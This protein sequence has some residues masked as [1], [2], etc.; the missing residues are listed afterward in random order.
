MALNRNIRP[1][2]RLAKMFDLPSTKSFS[3]GNGLDVYFSEKSKLPIIKI[4][5]MIPAGSRYDAYGHE[6]LAYLTSLLID[7][8]AGTYNALQLANE[9]DKLGSSIDISTGVDYIF[10]SLTSLTENFERTLELFSLILK[11]PLFDQ[12]SFEREKEKHIIKIIQSFDDSSYI[13]A[14]AF[15]R[16]IFKGTPYDKP[17]LGFSNSIEPF[18]LTLV[19]DFYSSFFHSPQANLIVVGN[20]S[21]DSLSELLTKYLGDFNLDKSSSSLEMDAKINQAELFF[22]HKEDAAQSEIIAGHL[23]KDRD[24]RD[25]LAAKIANSILGGQFSSR[26]NL[27][28][29]EDKGYTYGAHSSLNYNK[30]LGYFS[31]NTSVQSEFTLNAINEIRKEVNLIRENITEEEISFTKSSLVK[32]F[33]SFFETY[34]QIAQRITTQ[35]THDLDDY[36]ENYIQNIWDLTQ[37]EIQT[38]AKEYFKP[39]ELC[40]FIV[41]N[42][43]IIYNDLQKIMDLQLVE[44]NKLGNPI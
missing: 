5:L 17:I 30:Y 43:D 34:S 37:D 7:E 38:A 21:E 6:G 4:N 8:G 18:N 32:Q 24:A 14:N 40:F 2:S 29:R 41:G 1:K 10:L 28:L 44:L 27:N 3:L 11:R 33:P 26:I 22:I 19:K 25:H 9:I 35:V 23:A 13:G 31:V 36:Y 39:E 20:I 42:K 16:N 12:Q 15:Q